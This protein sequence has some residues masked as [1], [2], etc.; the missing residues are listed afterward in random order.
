MGVCSRELP[1]KI[2]AHNPMEA[3]FFDGIIVERIGGI[4]RDSI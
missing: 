3:R 2:L 1:V 4:L